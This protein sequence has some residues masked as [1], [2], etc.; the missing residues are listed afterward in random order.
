MFGFVCTVHGGG[1]GKPRREIMAL[2][3]DIICFHQTWP[4]SSGLEVTSKMKLRINQ[5]YW[6]LPLLITGATAAPEISHATSVFD[7]DFSTTDH[8]ASTANLMAWDTADLIEMTDHRAGWRVI[9]LF[10]E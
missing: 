1:D 5:L 3:V 7:E 10:P 4:E 6:A 8:A 2:E 9:L